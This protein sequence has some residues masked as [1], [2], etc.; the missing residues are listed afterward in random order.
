LLDEGG[1]N[2]CFVGE[3]ELLSFSC[4]LPILIRNEHAATV[5]FLAKYAFGRRVI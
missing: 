4:N 1:R 2:V 5:I 3:A